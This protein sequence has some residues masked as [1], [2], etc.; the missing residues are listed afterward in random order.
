M[1]NCFVYCE[2]WFIEIQR[3]HSWC[4]VFRI[5]CETKSRP[6][7][8]TVSVTSALHKAL[9]HPSCRLHCETKGSEGERTLN[10]KRETENNRGT[11]TQKAEVFVLKSKMSFHQNVSFSSTYCFTRKRKL[12]VHWVIF[13]EITFPCVCKCNTNA[14]VII[15]RRCLVPLS[16]NLCCH[17]VAQTCNHYNSA[18]SRNDV[19]TQEWS[20]PYGV[21]RGREAH[22]QCE[23][24]EASPVK[25]VCVHKSG[26]SDDAEPAS[27][28]QGNEC[29]L[30]GNLSLSLLKSR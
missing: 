14:S 25:L 3:C 15:F 13:R 5:G 27:S 30:M 12:H 19:A 17:Y 18:V 26:T 20:N 22:R 8:E 1:P 24:I 4:A 7:T 23:C 6:N 9:P 11:Q 10:H 21:K 2:K 29:N 28:W 16:Q